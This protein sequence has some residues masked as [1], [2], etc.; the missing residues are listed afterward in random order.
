MATTRGNCEAQVYISYSLYNHR[1]VT[2]RALFAFTRYVWGLLPARECRAQ[3]LDVLVNCRLRLA[4][5]KTTLAC[6]AVRH[7][8]FAVKT[9]TEKHAMSGGT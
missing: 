3:K 9:P 7:P 1:H 4:Y 2:T 6:R 8:A 5:G